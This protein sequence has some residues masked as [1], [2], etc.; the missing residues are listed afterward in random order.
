M[1]NLIKKL[2]EAKT[3]DEQFEMVEEFIKPFSW[4]KFLD[5]EQFDVYELIR[6]YHLMEDDDT[7]VWKDDTPEEE[8][9]KG[10][11]ILCAIRNEIISVD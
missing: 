3:F 11:E 9:A 4:Y 1:E 2:R 7:T 5:W 8:K 10:T 6:F